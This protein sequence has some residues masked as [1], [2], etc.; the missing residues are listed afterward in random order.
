M[1]PISATLIDSLSRNLVLFLALEARFSATFMLAFFL[2]REWLPPRILLS[3]SMVLSLFVMHDSTVASQILI[4][5]FPQLLAALVSQLI[6]GALTGIIINFFAEFFIGFGQT[7]SMQAGL[8]FVNLY[9]PRVGNIT[10][11]SNFFLL[12][13]IL[14]FFEMNAH[15]VLIKM[16]VESFTLI[17]SVP[18]F[19][20]QSLMHLLNYTSILFKGIV[21]LSLSVIFALLLT[22]FTLALLTKFAPQLNLFSIGINISLLLCLLI[23]YLGFDI[24]VENGSVL[25]NE[26]LFFIK[27]ILQ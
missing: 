6:L 8:G 21:M 14:I 19:K 11:L 26:L 7:V 17:P 23:L 10:P 2:R 3:L 5:N 25:C 15:L 1:N 20:T 4:T 16:L 9:I 18:V 27:K 13:A 12:L 24:L 22:N